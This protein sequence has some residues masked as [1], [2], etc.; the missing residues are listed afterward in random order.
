MVHLH[1]DC[2]Y[3]ERIDTE[4]MAADEGEWERPIGLTAEFAILLDDSD[5][6]DA[7][8]GGA[9]SH[10]CRC[11]AGG[12][13]SKAVVG[14][15]AAGGGGVGTG[16]DAIA[17]VSSS[18]HFRGEDAPRRPAAEC[19][20]GAGDDTERSAGERGEDDIVDDA[21]P[22]AS[23]AFDSKEA[24]LAS[25]SSCRRDHRRTSTENLPAKEPVLRRKRTAKRR[26]AT[27]RARAEKSAIRKTH[28]L[29]SSGTIPGG[30]DATIV[31]AAARDEEG[32]A[33]RRDGERIERRKLVERWHAFADPDAPIDQRR[34][35][36][37]VAA[38]LHARCQGPVVR[39]AMGR[40]R[41]HFRGRDVGV[42]RSVP[43][44]S[45]SSY[46]GLTVHSLAGADPE[47]DIAPLLS[48]VL[49]GNTKARQIVQAAR[50]VLAKFGGRVPES[51]SGLR[52]ITG[53]GPALAEI[54]AIVNR[55]CTFP[56]VET[57][58]QARA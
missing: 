41:E 47:G 13:K 29:F 46:R 15:G 10:S 18:R 31:D 23:F 56:E 44:L 22:F 19:V 27:E 58:A 30:D 37:L 2:C 45:P 32:E 48:S 40:L 11:R 1:S 33:R 9:S 54:L 6:D 35:Q 42:D 53:I 5:N 8:G 16:D 14:E 25:S 3:I 7:G 39:V 50:D 4:R 20:V 43:L 24:P 51:A 21:N 52:E 57:V 17:P 36:V 28:P 38:R 34:F 49:F 26:D 12:D 55:R